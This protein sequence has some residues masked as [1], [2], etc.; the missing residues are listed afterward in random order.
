[1]TDNRTPDQILVDNAHHKLTDSE[2][3]A[4]RSAIK[5]D[6]FADL[7]ELM[8]LGIQSGLF[9][10]SLSEIDSLV[11]RRRSYLA[12]ERFMM[13]KVG[14]RVRI[15]GNVKPK[16]L[17]H[18]ECTVHQIVGDKVEVRLVCTL[19]ERWRANQIVTLTQSLVGEIIPG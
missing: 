1:M 18:A 7:P 10:D 16:L 2:L 5:S 12:S 3:S 13:L 11:A 14:Q 15:S 19:S 4:L 17:A 9:D 6:Y 8:R